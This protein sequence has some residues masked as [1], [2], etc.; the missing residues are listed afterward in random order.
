MAAGGDPNWVGAFTSSAG[1]GQEP[2]VKSGAPAGTVV[3]GAKKGLPPPPPMAEAGG[4]VT[5]LVRVLKDTDDMSA[6]LAS[7]LSEQAS[8]ATSRDSAA[9]F[10]VAFSG[11]SL[12]KIAGAALVAAPYKDSVDWAAWR[13]FYADE[14]CVALDHADSN[15]LALKTQLLD[16]LPPGA[17]PPA[18]IFTIDAAGSP[19]EQAAA[20]EAALRKEATRLEQS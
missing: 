13:V 8:S 9:G 14:R 7:Y 19:A 2:G 18:Q 3:A 20:Y 10:A 17:I 5:H 16:K 1:E 11:G 15:H 4:G 12:P 6:S